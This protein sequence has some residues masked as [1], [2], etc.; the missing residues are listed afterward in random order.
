MN[1]LFFLLLFFSLA[2]SPIFAQEWVSLDRSASEGNAPVIK[3][4][5]SDNDQTTIL[6]KVPGFYQESL[7][8]FSALSLPQ[9]A[10]TETIGKSA[11]PIISG[12]IS[13]PS[14]TATAEV[15]GIQVLQSTEIL[16]IQASPF[17]KPTTDD[18]AEK[19]WT[20]DS[21]HYQSNEIFPKQ[22]ITLEKVAIWRNEKVLAFRFAPI[23]VQPSSGVATI[24][25]E[26]QFTIRYE[27]SRQANFTKVN[28][29]SAFENMY[30]STLLNYEAQK[31][32]REK[33]KYLMIVDN[34]LSL[35]AASISEWKESNGYDVKV[36]S[37]SEVGTT[38]QK[39]K[40]FVSKEYQSSGLSYLLLVG[41]ADTIPVYNWSNNPSD[42]WYSCISG[43]D[44]YADIAVGRICAKNEAQVKTYLDKMRAYEGHKS[45]GKDW[46][47][48]ALLVSHKE[49]APQKYHGCIEEVRKANY[50][51]KV[52]FSIRHGVESS[53]KN[54]VIE[55]DIRQ[56]RGIVTY[57]G[58]GQA[59][60]WSHWNG[61]NFTS[62]N[63]STLTNSNYPV[64]FSIACWNSRIDGASE[65]FAEAAMHQKHGASAFLG[66]TR[67]SYTTPNHDFCKE[68]FQAAFNQSISS[69]GDI[70][71]Y[72]NAQLIK[73][74]GSS[75]YAMSN[76]KMYL[77]LGDPS[78]R[79]H[80][81]K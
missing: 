66:A 37:L 17:Q 27:K 36:V 31:T 30:Q 39:I 4:V 52:L 26:I 62:L 13:I 9:A 42:Y 20:V 35:A 57:R 24:A 80:V 5:S 48:K 65:T 10:T 73:K 49:R 33:P 54:A 50:K 14:N 6:I 67:P 79:V 46:A 29:L 21:T 47:V 45:N 70:S 19:E 78:L 25:Q 71:N 63:L 22:R 74:Y 43:D 2:F 58:H 72:A 28:H 61:S 60:N 1:K 77:W 8:G 34:S 59:T 75:S 7:K 12:L 76:L 64:F 40:D 53:S 38:T 16:G 51:N 32:S 44:M 23:Q 68:L 55:G 11:L 3:V 15:S 81:V 18:E 56:G 41:D 69:V